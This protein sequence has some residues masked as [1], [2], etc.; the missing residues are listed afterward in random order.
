M[1]FSPIFLRFQALQSQSRFQ[2]NTLPQFF[3]LVLCCPLL[4]VDCPG[5]LQQHLPHILRTNTCLISIVSIALQCQGVPMR[6]LNAQISGLAHHRSCWT[7]SLASTFGLQEPDSSKLLSVQLA[8]FQSRP[9]L[10][11]TEW[12]E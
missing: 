10:P 8:I 5:L 6:P 2:P 9:I 4:P 11:I 3:I 7:L 1:L 12:P